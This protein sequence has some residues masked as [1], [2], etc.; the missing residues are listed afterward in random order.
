MALVG[1]VDLLR[2]EE[3]QFLEFGAFTPEGVRGTAHLAGAMNPMRAEDLA[4]LNFGAPST[5]LRPTSKFIGSFMFF[6]LRPRS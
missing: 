6:R 4:F 1:T 5:G 3:Q 2:P